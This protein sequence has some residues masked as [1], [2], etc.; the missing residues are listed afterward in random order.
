MNS[1]EKKSYED[2]SLNKNSE[3]NL[4]SLYKEIKLLNEEIKIIKEKT[5]SANNWSIF[6]GLFVLFLFTSPFWLGA[7][8]MSW[9]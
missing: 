8:I 6:V 3:K 9:I 7:A 4:E 2:E 1:I 5:I